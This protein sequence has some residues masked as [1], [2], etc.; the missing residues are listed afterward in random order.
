[1][2]RLPPTVARLRI[3]GDPTVRDAWARGRRSGISRMMR[4]YVTPDPRTNDPF[5][6]RQR[7]SSGSRLTS[8][9]ASG[10]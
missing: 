5:S 1:M 4:A 7:P 2:P 6:L 9:I 8:I 10:R 3:W